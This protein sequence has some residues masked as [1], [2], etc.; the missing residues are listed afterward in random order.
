MVH[1]KQFHTTAFSSDLFNQSGS[2]LNNVTKLANHTYW[3]LGL[4]ASLAAVAVYLPDLN[5]TVNATESNYSS[6]RDSFSEIDASNSARTQQNQFSNLLPR[7]FSRIN[8]S[9]QSKLLNLSK[10]N[11]DL[12]NDAATIL[13]EDKLSSGQTT[14]FT[15]FFDSNTAKVSQRQSPLITHTESPIV[16]AAESSS[17]KIQQRIYR[18]Q[19]GDTLNQIA[20]KYQVS[21][22]DLIELN[23]INNSNIIFVNQQLKIPATVSKTTSDDTVI[24]PSA[25]LASANLP[26]NNQQKSSKTTPTELTSTKTVTLAS[27]P[28]NQKSRV[29]STAPLEDRHIA[30]LKAEIDLLRQQERNQSQPEQIVDR[31]NSID[32]PLAVKSEETSASTIGF[33]SVPQNSNSNLLRNEAIALTLPPLPPSDEYLPSAFDGYIWPAQGVLTSG[34]GWRWGR[35]HRGIDIAAPIGTPILAAASGEVISAGWHG[36]YGNLIKLEHLDGSITVY[37]HNHRNLV[38]HGQ[39]VTQ[40]EQI[41][42]MGSTGNSTGSHLHFEIH[43]RGNA[44]LD[45]LA[46]LD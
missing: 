6:I 12:K 41:A 22:V 26:L 34:Y 45:P 8:S 4:T 40:G 36:G 46:L 7:V 42:E 28:Q 3:K 32:L 14:K 37:A 21:K 33:D 20:K 1:K 16:L 23:H 35:L 19:P 9:L 11:S 13:V 10:V 18:V 2:T 30:R 38:T 39:K 25:K 29:N 44:P 27:A 5:R 15:N 43:A 24:L 17:T 31:P